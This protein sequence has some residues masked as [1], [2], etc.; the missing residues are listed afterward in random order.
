M[1]DPLP[2][3]P[4]DPMS[5]LDQ[6]DGSVC[7]P[8]VVLASQHDLQEKFDAGELD[9]VEAAEHLRRQ[10][11]HA[12]YHQI[13]D[14]VGVGVAGTADVVVGDRDVGAGAGEHLAELMDGLVASANQ[15]TGHRPVSERPNVLVT[16][17]SRKVL[18]VR[19]FREND[20]AGI[21]KVLPD[22]ATW[23]FPGR[24]GRIAD[25]EVTTAGIGGPQLASARRLAMREHE[26]RDQ[27]DRFRGGLG[28]LRERA[29]L[30]RP[31]EER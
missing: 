29:R 4:T 9:R 23:A 14:A 16:S 25:P 17:A 28:P 15:F 27:T 26:W 12:E 10:H 5:A 13:L 7:A 2:L 22:H 21:E 19:A 6:P 24:A 18:L 3:T 20:L 30:E 31:R 11:D 8:A 1:V